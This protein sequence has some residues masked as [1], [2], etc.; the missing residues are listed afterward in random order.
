MCI[1]D[2]GNTFSQA[3][4]APL[5]ADSSTAS[6]M[7]QMMAT[8]TLEEVSIRAMATPTAVSYT[9]LDVYKR[10]DLYAERE[11]LEDELAHLYTEWEKL[12]AELEEAKS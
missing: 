7:P 10:Q 4:I 1:R 9:H 11:K 3:Y 8:T 6:R 2:R 5:K 12:A